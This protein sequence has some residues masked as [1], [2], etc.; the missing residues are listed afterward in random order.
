MLGNLRHALDEAAIAEDAEET[1]D[2][3]LKPLIDFASNVG[4]R[5]GELH[6]ALAGETDQE[7]FRPIS[8]GPED[9][10]RGNMGH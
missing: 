1:A 8:A 3:H 5:L 2:D 7:D 6:V 10:E 4:R 9:V